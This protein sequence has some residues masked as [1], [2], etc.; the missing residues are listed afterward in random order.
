MDDIRIVPA[1]ERYAEAVRNTL[2]T[3]VRMAA[4]KMRKR[5]M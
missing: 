4:V 2:S 5:L 3:S 1:A